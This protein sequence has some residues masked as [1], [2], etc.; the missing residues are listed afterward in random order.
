[1]AH[2]IRRRQRGHQVHITTGQ[3]VGDQKCDQGHTAGDEDRNAKVIPFHRNQLSLL[4]LATG[5]MHSTRR[6]KGK[7][8]ERWGRKA[9]GLRDARA[10]DSGVAVRTLTYSGATGHAAR[11][12][13]ER[14]IRRAPATC[15]SEAFRLQKRLDKTTHHWL[16]CGVADALARHGFRS[17]R[18]LCAASVRI[19]EPAHVQFNSALIYSGSQND[20]GRSFSGVMT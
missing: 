13:L 15:G 16:I 2:R 1:V 8:T 17:S 4:A 14:P 5:A 11:V 20:A 18:S 12:R 19:R 9:S 3:R 7:L 10:Y 6:F